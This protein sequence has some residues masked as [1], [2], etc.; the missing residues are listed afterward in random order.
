MM[1]APQ[2]QLAPPSPAQHALPSDLVLLLASRRPGIVLLPPDTLELSAGGA[3]R[4]AL[5]LAAVL[6]LCPT[7]P[8]QV[9]PA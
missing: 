6:A 1:G 2:R 3:C 5:L 8:A 7:A 9:T 4:R